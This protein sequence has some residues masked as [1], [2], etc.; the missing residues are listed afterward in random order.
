MS[1]YLQ[2]VLDTPRIAQVAHPEV[3]VQPR[4][5][6]TGSAFTTSQLAAAALCVLALSA[7]TG[8]TSAYN[9]ARSTQ[10]LVQIP[11]YDTTTDERGISDR[12]LRSRVSVIRAALGVSISDL[13]LIFDVSR[14]AIY[15]WLAG[16]GL[17]SLNQER[18][19]DLFLAAGILVPLS[20]S[21]G[22]SFNR[23][24]DRAGQTLLGALR[25]GKSAKL[26]AQ[27]VAFLL[28][29]E[30]KQRGYMD[31]ILSSHQ[32]S[33]PTARELGVPVLNEQSDQR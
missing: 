15:K 33:L 13:S 8:V 22:W 28:E 24:R 32:G 11:L 25:E 2:S 20:S 14:Q 1:Q 4:T 16:G 31:Q 29:D 17:S 30:R 5:F 18:F 7:P 6:S 19:E 27:D 23:R 26:W 21:E 9:L 3:Y 10:R 12:N